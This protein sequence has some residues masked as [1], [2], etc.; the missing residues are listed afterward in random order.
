MSRIESGVAGQNY[1]VISFV[2][3]EHVR[4]K[5]NVL[6]INVLGAFETVEE[7]REWIKRWMEEDNRFDLYIMEMLKFCPLDVKVGQVPT[8]YEEETMTEIMD[9]Y[10]QRED[11]SRQDREKRAK[12]VRE[13]PDKGYST[14]SEEEVKQAQEALQKWREEA[15]GRVAKKKPQQIHYVGSDADREQKR[16]ERLT[17]IIEERKEA[18][19]EAKAEE[20]KEE[21]EEKEEEK[22]DEDDDNTTTNAA[23]RT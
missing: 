2:G 12:L 22:E 10:R 21:D 6:A 15:D 13:S 19:E 7:A 16:S 20:N 4:T 18:A 1:A 5:S 17:K 3:P 8:V 9:A 14:P 23:F 11:K